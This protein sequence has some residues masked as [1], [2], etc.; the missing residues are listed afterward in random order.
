M[1]MPRFITTAQT[2]RIQPY[3][4]IESPRSWLRSDAPSISLDGT[5]AFAYHPA[6]VPDTDATWLTN[7][8]GDEIEVPGHWQLQGH[9]SPAYMNH[10]YPFPLDA[11]HVP[12]GP[13]GD[14]W[15]TFDL[16]DGWAGASVLLRFEGVDSWFTVAVNGQQIGYSSGSRLPS[17]FEIGALLHEGSNTLQ[18]RVWQWSAASYLEDQ[19]QWWLS[20]IFRGVSLQLRPVRGIRDVEIHAGYADGVGS[21]SCAVDGDADTR[22]RIPE[23]GID[24]AAGEAVTTAVE[25]WT[26]ES[27][28]L[29]DVE[30]VAPQETVRLR[31][32][33]RTIAIAQGILTVNGAA[34]MLRGVNR[35]EFHPD[36]GRTLTD[37]DMLTDVLLMKQHNINA[38]RTSHYPPH[39]RFLELCDEYGLYVM[40]EA[41][42]ETHGFIEAD[43]VGNP[44]DDDF[45]RDAC[46]DR[47][48]RMI[49]RDKN[50]PSVIMWSLGNE[51]G[52]GRN[53]VAMYEWSK[54]RDPA[55]PVH[56]E[57]DPAASDVFSK[58][59]SEYEEFAAYAR[60]DVAPAM[61][62]FPAEHVV[63]KPLILCEYGHAM[64]NGPGSI[65]E[66][67]EIFRTHPRSQGGF[68]WEWIDHGIRRVDGT[69]ACGGDFGEPVHDGRFCLDGLLFPD[70]M[71]SPG[72]LE[73]AAQIQPVRI[74]AETG[75]VR[76]TSEYDHIDTAHLRFC[77]IVEGAH[78][79]VGRGDLAVPTLA[80][81][82][83]TLVSLAAADDAARSAPDGESA[84]RVE[85]SLTA[86][87]TWADAEHVVARAD[88]P[89][90]ARRAPAT[91]TTTGARPVTTSE[92]VRFGPA[93]FSAST[94]MPLSIG[95]LRVDALRWSVWRAPIDNDSVQPTSPGSG[96]RTYGY[97]RML[98]WPRQVEIGD[99]AI[100]VSARLAPVGQG[101][102]FE[103]R[104]RWSA[105]DGLVRLDATAS[106]VGVWPDLPLPRLGLDLAIPG[107]LERADWFGLGPGESYPDSR[108]AVWL[109]RHTASLDELQAPYVVPQENGH[110][111]DVRTV[112]LTWAD[113]TAMRITGVGTFGFTARAWSNAELDAAGHI[114]ELVPGETAFLGI[115]AAQHAVGSGSCGPVSAPAFHLRPRSARLQLTFEVPTR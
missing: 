109:A 88:L 112:D 47:I 59:Y 55:R 49:E 111:S 21:F 9:G 65:G 12:D 52:K 54:D 48:E 87:A 20:G 43:W 110:R 23:L 27:P 64:G 71:P 115:D 78:G 76:I 66:Y 83:S 34:I 79:E 67:I 1:T 84:V 77:W 40:D 10:V 60:G 58:M 70:R 89:L 106:P 63:D 6:G 57:G 22:I 39:P 19:D 99:D 74:V 15:R 95:D 102:G 45:Y 51:A 41:D 56:Y 105:E 7:P 36:R 4:G 28:R 50:S 97:D 2:G 24:V 85:A 113:G 81:G 82:E 91:A 5:W 26:A 18:V 31:T 30:I 86:A 8:G 94:G 16:P 13:V 96:W 92:L 38:V 53:L 93:T 11:P 90:R 62:G 80:P 37:D 75:G 72:L 104:Y 114:H 73:Y 14:Y 107:V 68:I 69:Y 103:V 101:F 35:H 33:F 98:H 61:W 3:D 100:E 17:E 46:L 29:Y 42:Y 32:G 108:A 44:S 25:P